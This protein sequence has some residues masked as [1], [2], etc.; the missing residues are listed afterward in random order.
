MMASAVCLE[1]RCRPIRMFSSALR[2]PNTLV[3]WKVRTRPSAATWFALRPLILWS[4]KTISPA[5]GV[6]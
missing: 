1:R 5:A 2:P 4:W 6:R 3:F